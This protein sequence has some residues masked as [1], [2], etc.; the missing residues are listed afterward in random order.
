MRLRSILARCYCLLCITSLS[1]GCFQDATI[2]ARNDKAAIFKVCLTIALIEKQ[3]PDN[4]FFNKAEFIPLSV[5]NIEGD[6][7]PNIPGLNLRLLDST[8]L[9]R[10]ADSL[11]DFTFMEFHKIVQMPN[12]SIMITLY[13]SWALSQKT[14]NRRVM[15]MSGGELDIL[16]CKRFGE[17]VG[18]VTRSG[19]Y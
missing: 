13:H 5:K 2:L 7:I 6:S 19:I 4:H 18:E 15:M 11:G 17:W 1:L 3:L 12:G 16:C 10:R 8:Q 9:S 14:R